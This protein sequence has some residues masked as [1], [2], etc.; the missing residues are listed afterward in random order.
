MAQ[1]YKIL[2]QAVLTAATGAY[3]YTVPTLRGAVISKIV[4]YNDDAATATVEIHVVNAADG[5]AVAKNKNYQATV[6]TKATFAETMRVGLSNLDQIYFESDINN[7]AVSV[8]GIEFDQDN[9][10]FP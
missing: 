2:A 4:V 10:Y 1:T 8:Y 6:A 3:V 5:G 9:V 7:V